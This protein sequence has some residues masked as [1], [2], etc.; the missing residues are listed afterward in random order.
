MVNVTVTL[1]QK[2]LS[3]LNYP[4]IDQWLASNAKE[5]SY[6]LDTGCEMLMIIHLTL[7][8]YSVTNYTRGNR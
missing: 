1:Q 6:L 3:H 8:T 7:F 5:N 2:K 4:E